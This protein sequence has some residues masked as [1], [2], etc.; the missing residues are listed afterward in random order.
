MNTNLTF[1]DAA[2]ALL[3]GIVGSLIAAYI[4]KRIPDWFIYWATRWAERS[5]RAASAKVVKLGAELAFVENL[6]SD[7]VKFMGFIASKLAICICFFC[8]VLLGGLTSSEIRTLSALKSLGGDTIATGLWHAR[9]SVR[10]VV[11][12]IATGVVIC[13]LIA[14]KHLYEVLK[15]GDLNRLAL[16]L[17]KRIKR[18]MARANGA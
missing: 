18:L 4:F 9:F 14:L 3:L 11:M 6:K 13:A 1:V 10:F 17:E 15:F 12:T 2:A 8:T 7:P 16:S 5:K